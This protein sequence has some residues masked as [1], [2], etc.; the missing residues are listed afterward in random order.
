MSLS[1]QAPLLDL[2]VAEIAPARAAMRVS[3]ARY[4]PILV[5][6]VALAAG[7]VAVDTI[8]IGGFYDDAFYVILA[9]SL[10]TGHGYRNLN[11][12]GAPFA[13]HY[14]PG[15]PLFLAL[16]WKIGP[17]FPAN[18][19]LFK[20]ANVAFLALVAGFAYRLGREQMGL[21]TGAA[22]VAVIVGTATTPALYLSSMVLSETMFLALAIAL[23]VQAERMTRAAPNLRGAIGLGACTGLL[24]LVR[25]QAIALIGAIALV[26]LM[27]RRW[28]EAGLTLGVALGVIL[29]WI[30]WTAA[31]ADTVPALLRGDYGSYFAWFFDGV[32]ERGPGIVFDTLRRNVPDMFGHIAHRLRPPANPI[33]EVVASSCVALLGILGIARLVRRA[34]VTMAFLGGY[35][36]IVAVWPFAPVRFLLGVWVLLMLVLAAGADALAEGLP[37]ATWLGTKRALIARSAGVLASLV[38]V[39][40]VVAYN[41]R[42]YQRRWWATTE[43]LSARWIAPK[44]AWVGSH[45]DT[46]A[47][48][49][50]DHDEGTVYL[51]TGRHAV[52]VTTF[53]A[54]EYIEPR[55]VDGDAAA[56]DALVARF[57]P[58]YLV[59]SSVRL[60]PA[61][62]AASVNGVA[63]GDGDHKVVPWAFTLRR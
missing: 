9:K 30:L 36:A 19:V 15:Y 52:P 58:D 47:V 20:L 55:S 5:V 51:Y 31:H 34:P 44:L 42:G 40:G 48:I 39:G 21:G 10:A 28:R 17:A 61:A 6:V 38:L 24:F 45:T 43:E 56:L 29:P 11:L 54:T 63:L 12:P 50:T 33:P 3:F 46:S 62:A 59:L 14:P 22:L 18:L 35:L 1:T 4:A 57:K 25:S 49:A 32:R 13:T 8:P 23:L 37:N 41:V 16:L 26:Y 60:R 2:P 7:L 53:T 27:R